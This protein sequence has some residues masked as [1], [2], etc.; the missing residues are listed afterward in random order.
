MMRKI[1]IACVAA[2]MAALF[3]CQSSK[4]V[5]ATLAD[6][7]GEW[8]IVSVDG[9]D[10]TVPEGQEAPFIGFDTTEGQLFGNASCNYIMGSFDMNSEPGVIDFSGMAS[11]RRMCP[12]MAL[13][14][15][16]L[17]AF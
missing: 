9:V 4:T 17:E 11:T 15:K 3:A 16:I 12:D 13:E 5:K 10:V 2:S 7:K 6:L 14:Q 1:F 8:N